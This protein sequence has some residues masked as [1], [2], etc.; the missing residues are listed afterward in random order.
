MSNKKS[1][2]DYISDIKNQINSQNYLTALTIIENAIEDYPGEPSLLINAGNIYTLH[3]DKKKAEHYFLKSLS[4]N[5]SKEAH[6]NLSTIYLDYGDYEKSSSHAQS[7]INLDS[8]YIDA[9]YN[10]ALTFERMQDYNVHLYN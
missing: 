6:N 8:N 1:L 3:G 10:Y 4:I 2:D 7:A 5:D 9:H